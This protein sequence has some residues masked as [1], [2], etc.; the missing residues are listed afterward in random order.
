M[1]T[2]IPLKTNRSFAPPHTLPGMME[3]AADDR[4]EW[5]AEM[6][7]PTTNIA[8]HFGSYV[9]EQWLRRITLASLMAKG[10]AEWVSVIPHDLLREAKKQ[11]NLLRRRTVLDPENSD[12]LVWALTLDQLRQVLTAKDLTPFVFDLTGL[13]R[14]DLDRELRQIRDIRNIVAHHRATND[15]ASEHFGLISRRLDPA[16]QRFKLRILYF[17]SSGVVDASL[18]EPDTEL[19]RM[20]QASGLSDDRW[21]LLSDTGS[22]CGFHVVYGDPVVTGGFVDV[23]RLLDLFHDVRDSVLCIAL[24]HNTS[25]GYEG[26]LSVVWPRD[27]PSSQVEAIRDA[28]LSIHRD[29]EVPY[30]QQDPKHI[31]DP[32]IWFEQGRRGAAAAGSDE[33][34][35]QLEWLEDGS[36][37][38]DEDEIPL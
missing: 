37:D 34:R 8:I 12:N 14:R 35:A 26:E 16:I 25:E 33:A 28:C 19:G 36:A 18:T 11:V 2:T 23:G 3:H 21:Y 9:L 22:F 13:S 30:E 38:D 31:C 4:L 6:P 32:L 5:V 1:S 15:V 20:F 29:S 7:V 24:P 17:D 27:V 10:G